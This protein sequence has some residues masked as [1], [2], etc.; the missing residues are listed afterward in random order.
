M[1]PKAKASKRSAQDLLN[2]QKALPPGIKC[3]EVG[4]KRADFYRDQGLVAGYLK[5]C[6]DTSSLRD[7]LDKLVPLF[8]EFTVLRTHSWRHNGP[9]SPFEGVPAGTQ[10]I[11]FLDQ[12]KH[13]EKA[14]A[15]WHNGIIAPDPEAV[16]DVV[17]PRSEQKL[18]VICG[19]FA[20]LNVLIKIIGFVPNHFD[21]EAS[22]VSDLAPNAENLHRAYALLRVWSRINEENRKSKGKGTSKAQNNKAKDVTYLEDTVA[23]TQVG[24]NTDP[25]TTVEDDV[26]VDFLPPSEPSSED[27]NDEEQPDVDIDKSDKTT[28]VKMLDFD[29]AIKHLPPMTPVEL[30]SL[31][32][33]AMNRL[34]IRKDRWPDTV[35]STINE[36]ATNDEIKRIIRKVQDGARLEEARANAQIK[37]EGTEEKPEMTEEELDEYEVA[38][39]NEEA[40][41]DA[42]DEENPSTLDHAS[43][44]TMTLT[45]ACRYLGLEKDNLRLIPE[46]ASSV[47][48]LRHQVTAIATMLDSERV[49]YDQ[50]AEGN[51]TLKAGI[52]GDDMGLGK[53]IT[54]LALVY[55]AQK[56]GL[57]LDQEGNFDEGRLNVERPTIIVIP[58]ACGLGWYL[59]YC[60]FFP[61]LLRVY[62]VGSSF[63][64]G[65][66]LKFQSCCIDQ[67]MFISALQ[68]PDESGLYRSS[69]DIGR[70]IFFVSHHTFPKFTL[71]FTKEIEKEEMLS[72]GKDDPPSFAPQG[73]LESKVKRVRQK[74]VARAT[75]VTEDKT[76][77][78]EGEAYETF[79]I[80]YRS[81]IENKAYRVIIDEGH[82]V[83][84][85][86]SGIAR[87]TKLSKP[88][89]VWIVSATPLLNKTR[90]FYGYSHLFYDSEWDLKLDEEWLKNSIIDR[91]SAA[92]T[93]HQYLELFNPVNFRR[94]AVNGH[95][96]PMTAALIIPVLLRSCMIR[97]T[98]YTEIEGQSVGVDFPTKYVNSVVLL[99]SRAEQNHYCELHSRLVKTSLDDPV[100]DSDE[101][102]MD[103]RRVK[104]LL[105]AS[106]APPFVQVH[107]RLAKAKKKPAVILTTPFCGIEWFLRYSHPV[108]NYQYQVPTNRVSRA[109]EM[110]NISATLRY[111]CLI[112]HQV[113]TVL[114][115]RLTVFATTP[116]VAWAVT[117]FCMNW[118]TPTAWL[119]AGITQAERDHIISDF[120][121]KNGTLRVLITTHQVGGF[122]VNLHRSG[123]HHMVILEFPRNINTVLQSMARLVRF[124]QDNDVFIWTLFV[125]HSFQR[126]WCA[127]LARKAISDLGAQLGG[128][129]QDGFAIDLSEINVH[130]ENALKVILD[131]E[132]NRSQWNNVEELNLEESNLSAYQLSKF[133]RIAKGPGETEKAEKRAKKRKR[134]SDQAEN[135]KTVKRDPE[136][137]KLVGLGQGV[138]DDIAPAFDAAERARE[139]SDTTLNS[140][141]TFQTAETALTP[142]PLIDEESHLEGLEV[143]SKKPEQ[144][145][146]KKMPKREV[147]EG[148]REEVMENWREVEKGRKKHPVMFPY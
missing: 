8:E 132:E 74:A 77:T 11:K 85:P 64:R 124:G 134:E 89:Y 106:F 114:K 31:K 94:L 109:L 39:A 146:G 119:R 38:K 22:H 7:L 61:N 47:T 50:A 137:G 104:S 81:L 37:V 112:L 144:S 87:A 147:G 6:P 138:G 80:N 75:S 68:N 26:L 9:S 123:C 128:K 48:L 1:G 88:D 41:R 145:N 69:A 28:E 4:E 59:D 46:V 91:F 78:D 63:R 54:I 125:D 10:L 44:E 58:P 16:K 40:S 30:A 57:Q 70:T 82:V 83:R 49:A 115:K 127:N 5:E 135:R 101:G 86:G 29:E 43:K 24:A 13:N 62:F 36:P 20:T 52:L 17:D 71:A 66:D 73:E 53:T 51:P 55:L 96:N 21:Q 141:D 139:T 79:L 99:M 93:K 108:S 45:D 2:I 136:S 140:D 12:M 120:N 110:L 107:R 130:A 34:S 133:A 103:A 14:A 142:E 3:I 65:G 33:Y 129:V 95:I 25:M 122:G 19:L 100:P 118:G 92:S 143:T 116:D 60:Q 35:P 121:D 90:D 117:C 111:L 98:V 32:Q 131:W 148:L 15:L 27:E 105:C 102:G 113:V 126:W 76:L 97:R 56:L 23:L 72:P 67:E 18:Q 84:H 42:L